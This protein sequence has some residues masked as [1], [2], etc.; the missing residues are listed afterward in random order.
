MSERE[1]HKEDNG[2]ITFLP[3]TTNLVNKSQK[4]VFDHFSFKMS[5]RNSFNS[6][7]R[8]K[9]SIIN[10]M[11]SHFLWV[12]ADFLSFMSNKAKI[13]FFVWTKF[14][15]FW[16][17]MYEVTLYNPASQPSPLISHPAQMN[18]LML[19]HVHGE[20]QE[21]IPTIIAHNIWIKQLLNLPSS[22]V[23]L[24]PP[25]LSACLP[26]C[27]VWTFWQFTQYGPTNHLWT[28]SLGTKFRVP[29]YFQM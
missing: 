18:C 12:F 9:T 20:P 1:F 23:K 25:V 3:E 16:P 21:W 11:C 8:L 10:I 22:E 6:D 13:S 26:M 29:C 19:V 5:Y 4:H 2:D 14:S 17:V 28:P 24:S 27:V 7:F 15:N